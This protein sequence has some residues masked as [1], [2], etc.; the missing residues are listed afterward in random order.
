MEFRE[1][2]FGS[3]RIGLKV[4]SEKKISSLWINDADC[5]I[6]SFWSAVVRYPE[7]LMERI[8]EFTPTVKEFCAIR[9]ELAGIERMPGRRAGVVDL[10][11]K[12]LVAHQTSFSG[13]GAISGPLGGRKQ[14]SKYKVDSRWTPEVFCEKIHRIHCQF[15][16]VPVHDTR[17]TNLDF[18]ALIT[19]T[20]RECVL[21]LV[22]VHGV[23]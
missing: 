13:L 15:R 4:L 11:F 5:G 12:K 22:T 8:R 20:S 21:Y 16:G 1:P 9:D 7:D 19:D 17:C 14:T 23:K 18:A 6:A 3:G 2:F 10:G